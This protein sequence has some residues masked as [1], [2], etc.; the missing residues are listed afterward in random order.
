MVSLLN[1]SLVGLLLCVVVFIEAK[2]LLETSNN[3]LQENKSPMTSQQLYE[4]YQVMRTDPRLAAVSN[5]DIVA[6][7][8]KNYVLNNGNDL[9]GEKGKFSN[10]RY[11]QQQEQS[12]VQ[13]E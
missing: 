8:Y 5:Q 2:P 6:Y 7:I 9:N 1:V 13:T 12:D 3:I 4:L 10:G 11:R